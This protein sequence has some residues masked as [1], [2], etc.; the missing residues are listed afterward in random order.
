MPTG[1]NTVRRREAVAVRFDYVLDGAGW[2]TATV[3]VSG[4]EV[5]IVVSYL[6]DSLGQLADAILELEAGQQEA[7]VVFMS[8]P[9][10]HHLVFR[11]IGDSVAVEVRWFKDWASWG[12][13]PPERYEIVAVG[14]SPF[15]VVR[16]QV[17]AALN[18]VLAEHGVEGYKAK[19]VEHEFPVTA[20]ERLKH[21][22]P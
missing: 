14:T 3:L 21:A 22:E 9:G 7:T 2:A 17:V 11:R 18:R 16:E 5:A 13:Y 4:H 6:H 20:H 8:E 19:W 15:A 10:E 1:I 12:M